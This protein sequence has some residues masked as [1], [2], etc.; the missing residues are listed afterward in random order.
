MTMA[1]RI[2]I[3]EKGE[4]MQIATP[5]EIYEAPA[6]R[7]VADFVGTVN[8]FEGTVARR[9]GDGAVIEAGEGLTIAA[10]DGGDAS[11][12][13]R[14]W[15]AVRPEKIAVSSRPP[16]NAQVN[17]AQGEIWDIA[18]LGD[19]TLYHVRLPDGRVVRT[20]QLN[21]TRVTEDPLTW[22]DPAWISFQP[23][24]GVVLTR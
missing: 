2:A 16:P 14:V 5:A 3:M 23:D 21:A 1:D 24:S 4:I 17:A 12:G 18:Y 7:F 13:A 6:S 22:H 15:Y 8:L 11:P 19:M 20:S 9:D 10:S